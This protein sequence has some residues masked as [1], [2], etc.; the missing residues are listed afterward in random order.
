[1]NCINAAKFNRK[2]G[3]AEWRDLR[4]SCAL[5][6]ACSVGCFAPREIFWREH[7]SIPTSGQNRARYGAPSLV[8]RKVPRVAKADLPDARRSPGWR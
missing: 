6:M 1:M 8:V 7:L 4:F 3:V 2:F 5:L